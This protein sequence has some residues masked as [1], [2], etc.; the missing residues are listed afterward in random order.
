MPHCGAFTV[1]WSYIVTRNHRPIDV[2]FHQSL[3]REFQ[4]HLYDTFGC[5]S[6]RG[7]RKQKNSYFCDQK[8]D[9]LKA[10]CV[11]LAH[12]SMKCRFVH[13]AILSSIYQP[14]WSRSRTTWMVCKSHEVTRL[15]NYPIRFIDCCD[16]YDVV[17]ASRWH[18]GLGQRSN[19]LL[20]HSPSAFIR[21]LEYSRTAWQSPNVIESTFKSASTDAVGVDISR[22]IIV[23]II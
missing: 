9:E 13:Y 14:Q 3:V 6:L 11:F 2:D 5:Y 1:V 4:K 23:L 18:L 22:L 19:L 16:H 10:L 15:F 7:C 20:E 8:C 17:A 21:V 12:F